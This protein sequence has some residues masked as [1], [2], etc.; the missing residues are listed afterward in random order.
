MIN[1]L[2]GIALDKLNQM[3]LHD[4]EIIGV[5]SE[6]CVHDC[7]RKFRQ[8]LSISEKE[9]FKKISFRI[10]TSRVPEKCMSPILNMLSEIVKKVQVDSIVINDYGL[11]YCIKSNHLVANNLILG[12]T[13]IRTLADVPWHNLF[14]EAESLDTRESMMQANIMHLEKIELF[15]KYNIRGVELSPVD[16]NEKIIYSLQKIGVQCYVH[17]DNQIATIGRTCPRLRIIKSKAKGCTID[18]DQAIQLEFFE[19]YGLSKLDF[20]KANVYPLMYNINNV[21]YHRGNVYDKFEYQRSDGIIFDYRLNGVQEI[22]EKRRTFIKQL[23]GEA[24]YG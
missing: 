15:K 1:E 10:I 20:D 7:I 21:I 9:Y 18:C 6:G 11:L 5:G 12:R 14:V 4:G 23:K 16:V 8:L 13:L 24:T 3:E 22:E 2:R 19:P 17:Y